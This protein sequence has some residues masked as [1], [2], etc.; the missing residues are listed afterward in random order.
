MYD[1]MRYFVSVAELGTLTAAARK[2]HVTQPALTFALKRLEDEVGAVLVVRSRPKVGLTEAG[3]AFLP[4]ARA[5]LASVN[6]G[7]RAVEEVTGLRAGSVS[8]GAGATACT[9]YLPPILAEYRRLWPKVAILVREAPTRELESGL[10]AGELDL[11]LVS[12]DD[13]A[14]GDFFCDDE[15]VLV[16]GSRAVAADAPFVTFPRGAHARD[17][18]DE[19]FPEATIAMEIASIAA[20]KANVR[21][22]VGIALVSRRAVAR[23]LANLQLVELRSARTPVVRKL[24]LVHRGVAL[25]PPAALALRELLL[26]RRP[27]EPPQKKDTKRLRKRAEPANRRPPA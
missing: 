18:L 3:R 5:A 7:L 4:H 21:A 25:L 20:V 2:V 11:A 6:D 22:G 12:T 24:S 23:D 14:R 10:A 26:A 19:L 9:Y 15:L 1:L 13:G 8:I 16:A 27:N 17:V